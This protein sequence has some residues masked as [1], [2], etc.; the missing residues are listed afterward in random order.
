MSDLEKYGVPNIA[1]HVRDVT[2]RHVRDFGHLDEPGSL[3]PWQLQAIDFYIKRCSEGGTSIRTIEIGCGASTVIFSK[4]SSHHTAFCIG[5]GTRWSSLADKITATPGF[6]PARTEFVHLAAYEQLASA[7]PQTAVDLAVIGGCAAH[8][9]PEIEYF[10]VGRWLHNGSILVLRN[11]DVP[12]VQVLF[13][14][15]CENEMLY[16]VQAEGNAAFFWCAGSPV[17]TSQSWWN[18]R[19]NIESFPAFDPL[20]YTI[21]YSVPFEVAYDGWLTSLPAPFKKGAA[22]VAG[23][24]ALV[25]NSAKISFVFDRVYAGRLN[26]EIACEFNPIHTLSVTTRI[27]G[28]LQPTCEVQGA[29]TQRL[30]FETALTK[31]AKL[32]VEFYFGGLSGSDETVWPGANIRDRSLAGLIRS[33]AVKSTDGGVPGRTA[34]PS[35]MSCMDGSVVSFDV[36]GTTL[37]FFVND[38]HDSIQAHHAVGQLYETEELALLAPHILP[39]ARILDVGA[40]IGNHTVWFAKIAA[41]DYVLPIEPQPRMGQ[42]LRLNCALNGL[43]NVDLSQLGC[44]LGKEAGRGLITI[45]QAFNPAGASIALDAD[46]DVPV[47]VGDAVVGDGHF[48]FVKIDVEGAELDVVDGL[49]SMISRCR[50]TLFVEVQNENIVGLLA[51]LGALSYE[52]IGE[53]RRYDI[54]INILAR[55]TQPLPKLS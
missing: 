8:P 30:V 36:G 13:R 7:V 23:R 32:D 19:Y 34:P 26:V 52:V 15:L 50:P 6:D 54:A 29:A 3:S 18:Q 35:A 27:N 11:I 10:A 9:F 31:T 43:N 21:G 55:P 16:M 53:Y 45:P 2:G 17:R 39:G 44:A 24:P 28:V 4:S 51:R 1:A 14:V 42:L 12:S 22:L 20:A 49:A 41:A 25:G 48:D 5:E 47:H 38:P 46:G 40:N 37:R 33:I